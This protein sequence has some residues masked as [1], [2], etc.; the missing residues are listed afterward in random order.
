MRSL[1]G[2]YLIA[3]VASGLACL[4]ASMLVLRMSPRGA[5]IA[6]AE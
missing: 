4:L 2:S 6:A 1:S 5:P 3:F